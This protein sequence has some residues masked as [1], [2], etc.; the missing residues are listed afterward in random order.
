[1]SRYAFQVS[2]CRTRWCARCWPR[3]S[4]ARGASPA[5]TPITAMSLAMSRP[6]IYLA[7]RSPRRRELLRQIDVDFDMVLFREGERSDLDVDETPH[8]GEDV[9]T[10]VARLAVM[11]AE[12]GARRVAMRQ[13]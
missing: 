4:T 7:P 1:M 12:P 5:T 9:E 6:L 11:K 13:L 2:R 10:Y 3:R 8:E